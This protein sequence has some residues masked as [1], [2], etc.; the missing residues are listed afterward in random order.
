MSMETMLSIGRCLSMRLETKDPPGHVN[1]M[2]R[3]KKRRV[4]SSVSLSYLLHYGH[5]TEPNTNHCFN[6]LREV[7]IWRYKHFIHPPYNNTLCILIVHE[8]YKDH[9]TLDLNVHPDGVLMFGGC[10]AISVYF[11]LLL[12]CFLKS[13]INVIGTFWGL[14]F[15]QVRHASKLAVHGRHIKLKSQYSNPS[16][17]CA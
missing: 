11:P 7:F 17:N 15:A 13:S 16:P 3:S 9:P 10:D 12:S 6:C 2:A 4:L 8:A 1:Q 14:W 5:S